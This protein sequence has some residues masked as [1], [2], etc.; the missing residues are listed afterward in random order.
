[1]NAVNESLQFSSS[2][3]PQPNFFIVGAAKSGTTSLWMYLKQHP[4]IFMPKRIADKEP[5][6]FCHLYGYSDFDAYLRLF[7]DVKE[8]KAIGEAS[9][10]YLTSPE[11]AAWIKKVYPQA[12]IIIV[13]RNPVDR[14]YSL[15]NW[16]ISAGYE[17]IDSFEKALNSEEERLN[18]QYFKHNNPQFYYNYL[19]FSSGLYD[20]QV[21]RYLENFPRK[22]VKI[23]LFE[24]LK[25]NPVLT[26]QRIFNFLDVD[27]SFVPEVSI[28]NP[29]KLPFSVSTQYFTK[30]KLMKY[31][32]KLH[33][34]KA[35]RIQKTVL[36]TNLFFGQFRP[37]YLTAETRRNLQDRYRDNILNTA[38][39]IERDLGAWL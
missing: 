36:N 4:E 7:A 3:N 19:Y 12:K 5:S 22:K 24:E 23:I 15:Y 30:Q 10:A 32:H 8:E 20:L 9:H 38:N 37:W 26:T 17:W 1:M 31:L 11:S 34:P 28:H 29:G 6:F 18:N 21:K 16:M 35:G 25:D 33:I 13:L 2:S 27:S 14:A 39:L